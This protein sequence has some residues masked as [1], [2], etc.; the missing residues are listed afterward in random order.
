V[1]AAGL[2]FA[3]L[4]VLRY[5]EYTSIHLRGVNGE[6]VELAER[7]HAE[8][9]IQHCVCELEVPAIS[10]CFESIHIESHEITS[11][12]KQRKRKYST[13]ARGAD[14]VGVS[15]VP[16]QMWQGATHGDRAHARLCDESRTRSPMN[17]L[18][19]LS[20]GCAPPGAACNEK[21]RAFALRKHAG[22]VRSRRDVGTSVLS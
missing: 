22:A 6:V 17:V 21:Q 2:S 5:S 4:V 18:F 3:E 19:E 10:D 8:V 1:R 20:L 14:A 12:Q 9:E 16:Q 13:H 15:P 11:H 7:R